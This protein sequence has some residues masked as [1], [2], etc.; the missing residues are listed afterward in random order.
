M[1]SEA[2]MLEI[3]KQLQA[4]E[5]ALKNIQAEIG[6]IYGL[7]E[8]LQNQTPPVDPNAKPGR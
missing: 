5:T 6:H 3:G 1:S 2:A 8:A 7:L 4:Q